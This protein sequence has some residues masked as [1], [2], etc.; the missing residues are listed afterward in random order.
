MSLEDTLQAVA[1]LDRLSMIRELIRIDAD[2]QRI[3]R[4]RG[5]RARTGTPERIRAENARHDSGRLGAFIYFLRFRT[6][7]DS[8]NDGDRVLCLMLAEKLE[9]KGQWA[10]ECHLEC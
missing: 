4:G 1:N 9:A 10:G 3:A 2:L 7:A 8:T 5:N 6:M